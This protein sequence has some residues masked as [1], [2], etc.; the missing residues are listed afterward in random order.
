[1]KLNKNKYE[2]FKN[3][4]VKVVIKKNNLNHSHIILVE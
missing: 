2:S 4:S 1:M 3:K